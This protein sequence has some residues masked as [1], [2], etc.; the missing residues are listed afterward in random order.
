MYILNSR[1]FSPFQMH[2]Y[3]IAPF[4]GLFVHSN[5]DIFFASQGRIFRKTNG[6]WPQE[7]NLCDVCDEIGHGEAQC[8]NQRYFIFISYTFLI[9]LQ[10]IISKR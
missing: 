7:A 9:L 3:L 10:I 8:I 5:G 1:S 2:N 4:T 6:R